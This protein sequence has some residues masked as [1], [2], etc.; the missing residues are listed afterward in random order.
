MRFRSA[1]L[2]VLA[3]ILWAGL[4][5][6]VWAAGLGYGQTVYASP[7]STTVT[8]PTAYVVPRSYYLPTAYV[9]PS[10]YSTSYVSDPLVVGP[11]AYVETAYRTGLFGRRWVVERS[12]VAPYSSA[13]LPTTYLVPTYSTTRYRATTFVPTVYEYPRLWE[14]AYV[15]PSSDCDEVVWTRPA[16][17][18]S[19][20]ARTDGE[21]KVI[22]SDPVDDPTIPSDVEPVAG[23]QTA[24]PGRAA[25]E[26]AKTKSQQS[27]AAVD[28]PP[29]VPPVTRERNTAAP[30]NPVPATGGQPTGAAGD[31]RKAAGT[32]DATKSKPATPTAPSGNDDGLVPAPATGDTSAQRHDSMRP[33]YITR[34]RTDLRNVLIGR[35]E[36]DAGEAREKVPVS[37]ISNSNSA[38]RH[39]G[40]TNA[41]GSFAI[42]LTD[43]EWTVNVRMPSGRLH[44]IRSVTVSNGKVVDNRE[45]R[46]V[47]NLIITY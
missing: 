4:S 32:P 20:S 35:V 18:G 15:G 2:P 5:L 3:L 10:Y 14:T 43:G 21:S 17:T 22:R 40:V 26:V 7:V 44:A 12:L 31:A 38:V 46:E 28:S 27:P 30:A 19:A 8:F 13:Y 47:R 11:A 23:A 25:D 45:G 42:R 36:T 34:T 41:F 33:T 39:D 1:R 6:S 29:T 37:V 24:A 16:T 9:V